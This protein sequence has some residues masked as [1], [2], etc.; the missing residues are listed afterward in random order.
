MP[1][2]ANISSVGKAPSQI[3]FAGQKFI[4]L[5]SGGLYWQAQQTLL[6][7]DLHLEKMSSFARGGQ[8]LP[9]Y[10]SFST[11]RQLDKDIQSLSPKRVISLGDSF[12]RDEGT[13][14]L[15]P[16]SR[17]LLTQLVSEREWIWVAGN[18]DPSPHNL[19][20]LCCPE[21]QLEGI[22]LTHEPS[23][24]QTPTIA[25]HL[26]PA[27]RIHINGRSTRKPCFAGDERL[28][29]LPAYGVS[30]GSINILSAPFTGLFDHAQLRVVMLGKDTTYPVSPKRL[31]QG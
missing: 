18:H 10:D 31:I 19:G 16:D 7:A 5:P 12:H 14:T 21:L 3:A 6:V 28:L 8:F 17:A 27:A 24:A 29:L 25:G 13:G 11:L 22:T 1:P 23:A 2:P 9:P 26:H 30:T 20:G 15:P 4:P